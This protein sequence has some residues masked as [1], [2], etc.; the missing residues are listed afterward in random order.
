MRQS[1]LALLVDLVRRRGPMSRSAL[2]SATGLTRSAIA[3]LLGELTDLRLLVESAP[4]PDGSPGRPSPV[5]HVDD[6]HVGAIAVEVLV[7][8]IAAS[9]VALD[10]SIVTSVRRSRSRRRLSMSTTVRD[11]AALVHRVD[12]QRRTSRGGPERRIVGVG[13]SVPGLIRRADNSVVVAPNLGWVNADFATPLSAAL[14]DEWP[15][16][17]GNDADLGALAEYRFGAGVGSEHLLFVSGEVGVGGGLIIGGEAMAGHSGFAGEIGHFPVNP[18]GRACSCGAVG[19]WETEVGEAAMLRRA[20]LPE[21]GGTPAVERLMGALA[22][23]DPAALASLDDEARWLA[24]GFTGLINVFDPDLVVVGGLLGR[25]LPYLDE[26]LERDL[27]A[28]LFSAARGS[29]PIRPAALGPAATTVGAA[30]LAFAGLCRDPASIG[31]NRR[32]A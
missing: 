13:V 17:I 25:V 6:R 22:A 32:S 19:C 23:A 2:V 8:E 24:V 18:A 4:A 5:V 29:V 20:G 31:P 9:I 15:V 1:N 16:A 26:R 12:A 14:G 11:V 3:G 10:G 30:E 27:G 21:D 7:D 28:R